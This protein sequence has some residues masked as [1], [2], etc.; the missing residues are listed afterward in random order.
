MDKKNLQIFGFFILLLLVFGGIIQITGT[1]TILGFNIKIPFFS[2]ETNPPNP[3]IVT[4]QKIEIISFS[5][6]K[7]IYSTGEKAY[8]KFIVENTYNLP[9]DISVNWFFNDSRYNQWNNKS[10]EIYNTSKRINPF[11][12]WISLGDNVGE[13]EVQLLINYKIKN[14]TFIKEN[15]KKFRVI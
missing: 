7:Q 13:W 4:H 11:E 5:P 8:V 6:Q 12:S 10:T 15:I 1:G 2:Q 14:K 9:Y 3:V